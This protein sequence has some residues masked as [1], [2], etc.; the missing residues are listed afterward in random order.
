MQTVLE[1][2]KLAAVL[3]AAMMLGNWFLAEEFPHINFSSN[4]A[5]RSTRASEAVSSSLAAVRSPGM[6]TFSLGGKPFTPLSSK[7][8]TARNNC[9]K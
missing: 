4:E 5:W 8:S 1:L 3:A 9:R 6:Y 2:I 7:P